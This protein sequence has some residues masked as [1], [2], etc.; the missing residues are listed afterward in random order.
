MVSDLVNQNQSPALDAVPKL[1]YSEKLACDPQR[2]VIVSACAGS[3]KTWLL[4]ARMIRLLLDGVKPQEILALTFTRKAAQ[5]MRDRLYGL[6]EEFSKASPEVLL[7]ELK[8][9]GMD[10]AQ[11]KAYLP[12]AKALYAQVLANPQ[13]I[14]IDTFHGWFGRLLGAAPVSLGIQ[15]G[16]TL[17]EDAKRLQEECLRDWWGDLKPEHK[18]HYDV[19]LKQLGAHE[20]QKLLIGKASLFKQRG[21]WTFFSKDCESKGITPSSRL[22]QLLP[23][24]NVPNPLLALWDAPNALADLEFMANCLNNSSTNDQKLLPHLLPALACKKRGGGVMEV[25]NT[26]Q[27]AFLTKDPVKYR[28]G[29][30]SILGAL[31][32]YLEDAGKADRIPDHIAYKQAWGHAFEDY[33]LWQSEQDVFTINQAW[34]ALNESMMAYAEAQKDNMRV[35]DFDDL[36]IDVSKLMADSGNAAYLQVR[37]DAKYKQILV[38]EFQDTNPLQWQI[39]RSWLAGYSVDDD[40]PKVFIVGDPK[41]SIYRFRRADPRLF[42]SAKVFLHQ[43]WQAAYMEQDKTRRN[44]DQINEAVNAIFK[45]DLL[46]PAY[47]YSRQETLWTSPEADRPSEAYAL[48]GEAYR[49]PLIPY[50]EKNAEPRAGS[51]FDDAI[52]DPSETVGVI[53]RYREGEMVGCL[54]QDLLSTRKVADKDGSRLIWRDARASDFLLLVK[55]R[56]FL[57]QYERALRDAG[58]AYDSSRLG[59]LLNTLEIDDLIA[60][61]TVL[62]TP[63]HDLPLAQVLRSPIF[64]FTEHQM[65]K[66]AMAMASM[67]YRSWWDALQDSP[68]AQLQKAARYLQHWHVLGERLPVHD[69]LDRIYQ[70]GDLRIK[71]ARVCKELNRPQVLA[72]LD[73]FLEV[74]LQQDGGQYPSLSHFI[75]EINTKRRG[76]DDETPDEGDV[77][78]ASDD[79][80]AEV[81]TD[82]EMSEE[83]KHKRVRL[84]TIHGAKGLEAPFV[85]MLDSNNTDAHVDY[86]GVLMEWAPEEQSPSHLSLFTSQTLTSPRTEINDAEKRIGE[87]ENWNLLYVAMTRARQGLWM[88]GDAQKPSK[89]NPSG[90][91]NTSWY[92]KAESV[93]LPMYQLPENIPAQPSNKAP[94]EEAKTS[95]VEDFVINWKPAIA[96]EKQLRQDIEAGLTIQVFAGEND[97]VSGPD[98]ELLD[99]GTHFHKLLEFLTA[100]TGTEIKLEIPSDLEIMAWLDTDQAMAKKLHAHVQAV[101]NAN[102]LKPYLTE[103]KWLQAWNELDIVSEE[104]KSYRMDRLVEFEDHFAILDYKLSIPEAGSEKYNK[105]QAQLQNYQ[106]ELERIRKDKPSKAYL[107]SATGQITQVA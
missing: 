27:N 105:Y 68:D 89:N 6:L 72:N 45:S 69:L 100:Q 81:D 56:Q 97:Q 21:A 17:R 85:I 18:A 79:N 103:S 61:L 84:M 94:K 33:L 74:A 42:V 82:S 24:L 5:E 11:A 87:N 75:N 22:K 70:E 106:K 47:P 53:Q 76:D 48:K 30:D 4:V 10:E 43:E 77:D 32:T 35:R 57:P 50:A 38:D 58:L 86:S 96:S 49:L 29:N 15:P 40:K 73:A 7:G 51:A 37:L 12:K 46:P 14:V 102:E 23:K 59:G 2:S 16:F 25:V 44:A 52:M 67:Q 62:V 39:L 41:Q 20:A 28:T 34:F 65:Q 60:L 9:R 31:K 83:D 54:I 80:L 8:A 98:P 66:L 1:P 71:Y 3:G 93:G 19:L 55:R 91:D 13:P 36:E 107:I 88:S 92:G 104:G 64:G 78:A 99:E 90:L 101:L 26:F 95:S 63:R